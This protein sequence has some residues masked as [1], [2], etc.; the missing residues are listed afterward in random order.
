[1]NFLKYPFP[2][3]PYNSTFHPLSSTV[4]LKYFI[5]FLFL[6]YIV[7]LFVFNHN[8]LCFEWWITVDI[9][10]KETSKRA[11]KRRRKLSLSPPY[12][13]FFF[14]L[15]FEMDKSGESIRDLDNGKI[16][17]IATGQI[18]GDFIQINLLFGV[19]VAVQMPV[20]NLFD[21]VF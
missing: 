4:F 3:C 5:I 21:A 19:G 2:P 1:M 8:I 7:L 13:T 15:S 20:H 12:G 16:N 6:P 17:E 10:Y 14:F 18:I 11:K 9:F